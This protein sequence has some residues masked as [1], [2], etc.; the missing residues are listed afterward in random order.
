MKRKFTTL[1]LLVSLSIIGQTTELVI[2]GGVQDNNPTINNVL[3]DAISELNGIGT[4]T[5]KGDIILKNNFIIP[6]GIELHFF[7]GNKLIIDN[8][9]KL[10]LNGSIDAGLQQ[11]FK[12]NNNAEILGNSKIKKVYPHWWGA[13][14]NDTIPDDDSIKQSL[15]FIMRR[16]KAVTRIKINDTKTNNS[17]ILLDFAGGEFVLENKVLLPETSTFQLSNGIIRANDSFTGDFLFDTYIEKT[18][19]TDER[20]FNRE[21][22]I[23]K[24]ITLNCNYK[25][26]GIRLA[27]SIRWVFDNFSVFDIDKDMSGVLVHGESNEIIITNSFFINKDGDYFDE[28]VE[29]RTGT[30]IRLENNGNF[31]NS[32]HHF[33]NIAMKGLE[34]GVRSIGSTANVYD[35]IHIY[36]SFY[37]MKLEG[38]TSANRITACYF[39]NCK[40]NIGGPKM[41]SVTNC[42][43][44]YVDDDTNYAPF[45]IESNWTNQNIRGFTVTN[46]IFQSNIQIEAFKILTPRNFY[47][48]QDQIFD[49]YITNNTSDG[50]VNMR[51]THYSIKESITTPPTNNISFID[52]SKKHLIGR[53]QE[54][55]LGVTNY[56]GGEPVIGNFIGVDG[57][58][59]KV[60]LSKPI[61]GNL[62]LK[63]VTSKNME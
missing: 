59:L 23:F 62:H 56:F 24:N 36:D 16:Q 55:Y 47:F 53:V 33:T 3:S 51:G 50:N 11:I 39:D 34:Y 17:N 7:N 10:T 61:T 14:Q 31:S 42:Y 41:T 26:S 60:K 37:G 46:N 43:F 29:H 63:V 18:S 12:L 49:T 58:S 1:F 20:R 4:L 13:V 38:N 44:I 52:I 22:I 8:N 32:D 9:V 30:G 19:S 2:L 57:N 28:G 6:K 27:N 40:L 5:I 21:N 45:E 35:K 54:F 15:N 48:N 25:T